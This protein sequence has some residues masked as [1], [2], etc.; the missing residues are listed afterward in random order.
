[1]IETQYTNVGWEVVEEW[2]FGL[3]FTMANERLKGSV[4][5]YH[6]LT[7]GLAFNRTR[8]LRG[9]TLYGNF[10]DVANS[11]FEFNLNWADRIGDIGYRI[12]G[13][14]TTLKNEVKDLGGIAYLMGGQT[15]RPVRTEVGK[16]LNYFYG[17]EVIGIY[18]NQEQINN[19][20]IARKENGDV[21]ENIKPGY[22]I[23]KDQNGDGVL[24]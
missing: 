20:P 12:G 16:P 5:Y 17:Y 19:D 11:G 15:T 21:D 14:L 24:D 23:Y 13:N 1:T 8:A 3:D 22:F 4:D 6:R 7:H 10:G 2:D 18:Q 9:G